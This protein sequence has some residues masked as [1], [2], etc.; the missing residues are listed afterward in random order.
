MCLF[1]PPISTLPSYRLYPSLSR[2]TIRSERSVLRSRVIIMKIGKNWRTRS[3]SW[4]RITRL[5]RGWKT[6]EETGEICLSASR[7]KFEARR[8]GKWKLGSVFSKGERQREENVFEVV[9]RAVARKRRGVSRRWP[10]ITQRS[11]FRAGGEAG[12]RNRND[13]EQ[14]RA[15]PPCSSEPCPPRHF[16]LSTTSFPFRFSIAHELASRRI[17]GFYYGHAG[18]STSREVLPPF[19]STFSNRGQESQARASW[20][21]ALG[22][23]PGPYVSLAPPFTFSSHCRL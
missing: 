23:P 14:H 15:G 6:R 5:L 21:D 9:S 18:R 17:A 12:A 11:L 13:L 2:T 10:N 16:R 19:L 1:P 4:S 3:I 22:S 20:I 7:I 8:E